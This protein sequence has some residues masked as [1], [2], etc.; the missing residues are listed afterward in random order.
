MAGWLQR[1]LGRHKHS[2]RAPGEPPETGPGEPPETDPGE[3]PETDP[4]EPPEAPSVARSSLPS[5]EPSSES[6]AHAAGGGDGARW[7]K[8]YDVC[9]CHSEG[10]LAPAHEL[11]SYLEEG[12]SGLRCFLQLR[13]A[14][15]GGAVVSELCQALGSSHC[16]VLLLSPGFLRDPW[17]KY[18][19]LQALSEAPGAAGRT[20]PLLRGLARADY[21]AELRYMYYVDGSRPDGGFRQVKDTV[22]RYLQQLG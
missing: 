16:W 21:P 14:A 4:G 13:D 5:Q 2:P 20:I 17:C 8:A 22:L 19:M 6:R 3:P 12:P 7:G 10:D 18:Q 9:V 1:I 11:V 15:P